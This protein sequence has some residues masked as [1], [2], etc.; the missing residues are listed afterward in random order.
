MNIFRAWLAKIISP[1]ISDRK[2]VDSAI[3]WAFNTPSGSV[4][5]DYL[6]ASHYAMITP[7]TMLDQAEYNEG[8]RMVIQDILDSI[9][10]HKNGNEDVK[11]QTMENR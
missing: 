5:L 9:D 11:V 7:P 1:D 4:A 3:F 6:I 10:R 2:K 8:R